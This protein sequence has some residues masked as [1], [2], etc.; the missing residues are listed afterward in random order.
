[1]SDPY[2][3]WQPPPEKPE[4]HAPQTSRILI[5]LLLMLAGAIA[6]VWLARISPD[7]AHGDNDD[8]WLVRNVA[9]LAVFSSALIYARR[10]IN[11]TQSLRHLAIWLGIFVLLVIGYSY[12]NEFIDLAMRVRGELVPSYAV[13]GNPHEVVVTEA[14]G[15]AYRVA[16]EIDGV[17]ILFMVDTGAAD[18]VLSPED[19]RRLGLDP[20]KLTYDRKYET[21]NGASYGATTVVKSMTIGNQITLRDVEVSVN[22]AE[23]S[24]SLL[25]MSFLRRLRSFEFRGRRL[26]LRS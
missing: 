8:V 21:A 13:A 26:Y 10:R 25:G 14:T 1:M 4:G 15:G 16:G 3:P 7:R 11:W 17:P 19:A 23:M 12:Q 20:D 18:V 2:G 6:L 22:H 5:W 9:I 24:S